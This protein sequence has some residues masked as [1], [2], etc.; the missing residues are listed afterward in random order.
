[1][2]TITRTFVIVLFDTKINEHIS[3]YIHNTVI[4]R[5]ILINDF[6][7]NEEMVHILTF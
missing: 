6:L 1:M 3:E 4:V 2:F 7:L 5:Q